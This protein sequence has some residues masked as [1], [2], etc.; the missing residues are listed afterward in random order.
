M[1][2]ERLPALPPW[3]GDPFY[4]GIGRG[5][6]EWLN[7]RSVERSNGGLGR[8]F[9]HGNGREIRGEI[10]QMHNARDQQDR[11]EDEWSVPTSVE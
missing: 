6:H 7:D 11:Q 3:Y 4:R 9:P 1:G 10:S 5:R 8:G 2:T